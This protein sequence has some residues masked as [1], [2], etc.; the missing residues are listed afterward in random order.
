MAMYQEG[1][2]PEHLLLGE[3]HLSLQ[4]LPKSHGQL[5]VVRHARDRTSGGSTDVVGER[6]RVDWDRYPDF[7]VLADPDGN[8]FCIVDLTH[9]DH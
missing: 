8:G 5:F 9:D 4:Q 6:Q 2:A 1:Q 3:A 7:V